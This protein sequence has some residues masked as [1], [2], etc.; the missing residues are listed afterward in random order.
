MLTISWNSFWSVKYVTVILLA[1]RISPTLRE[2]TSV[3][4]YL[5]GACSNNDTGYTSIG[6]LEI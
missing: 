2:E 6:K 4:E 1:I 3:L 5:T